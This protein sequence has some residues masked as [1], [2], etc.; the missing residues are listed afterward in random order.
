MKQ[1]ILK[2]MFFVA[3]ISF[4]TGVAMIS[5][6]YYEASQRNTYVSMAAEEMEKFY[7]S[8]AN[9]KVNLDEDIKMLLKAKGFYLT[10]ID[11]GAN[12][13]D[14]LHLDI[15]EHLKAY[16]GIVAEKAKLRVKKNPLVA[17]DKFWTKFSN[18]L[19]KYNKVRLEKIK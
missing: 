10:A 18:G 7:V 19:D 6:Q 5:Y 2:I 12:P 9:R 15:T 13:N 4:T 1:L 3:L 11:Y 16:Q 8:T 17:M 14:V